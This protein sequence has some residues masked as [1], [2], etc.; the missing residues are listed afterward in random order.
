MHF[1]RINSIDSNQNHGSHQYCIAMD[2]PLLTLANIATSM[3]KKRYRKDPSRL[4]RH[5]WKLRK[6]FN[7]I[8]HGINFLHQQGVIHG[9]IA[10]DTCGKFEDGWKLLNLIGVQN[11]GEGV[12]ASRM[13]LS[14]PP[15]GIKSR[16][17][18]S[19]TRMND[20]LSASP[21]IDI[22]AFGKLMFEVVVQKSLIP[23]DSSETIERQDSRLLKELGNW[24]EENLRDAVAELEMT[25]IGHLGIDLISHCLCSREERPQS[26]QEVMSHGFWNESRVKR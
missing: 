17:D 5:I 6:V 11:L 16:K 1:F 18:Q 25:G 9:N 26:M 8:G 10:L 12:M 23:F 2:K 7:V 14:I 19:S 4:H 3:E 24:N 22:W 20:T 21:T 13:G 15:E